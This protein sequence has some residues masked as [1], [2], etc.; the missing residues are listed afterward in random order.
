[1]TLEEI[2]E[3]VREEFARK[4]LVQDFSEGSQDKLTRCV[5]RIVRRQIE[6][7]ERRLKD[8]DYFPGANEAF[9]QIRMELGLEDTL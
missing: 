7:V 4:H 9:S 1:M 2:K 5:L 6:V 8:H 3:A